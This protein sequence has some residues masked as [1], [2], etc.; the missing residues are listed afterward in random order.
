MPR[1]N[2]PTI[3]SHLFV[4]KTNNKNTDCGNSVGDTV[5]KPIIYYYYSNEINYK[6]VVDL[7]EIPHWCR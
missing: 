7:I 5:E 6:S 1:G 2:V 3:T 4:N